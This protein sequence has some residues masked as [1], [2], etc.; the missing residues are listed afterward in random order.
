M[1]FLQ[2]FERLICQWFRARL[3]YPRSC[4]VLT[5][6]ASFQELDCACSG[7]SALSTDSEQDLDFSWQTRLQSLI[8]KFPNASDEMDRVRRFACF[9]IAI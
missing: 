4:S 5:N 3:I 9:R 6:H 8:A 7:P 1:N 2:L